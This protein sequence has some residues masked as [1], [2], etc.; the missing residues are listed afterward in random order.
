MAL[1]NG[2]K[3]GHYEILAL[4]GKGGMGEV[5]RAH[6]AVLGREVA[7]KILPEAFAR[8]PER[9]AR[10]FD[11]LMRAGKSVQMFVLTCRKRLFAR[12]ARRS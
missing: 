1:A 4:I 5:Y 2:S 10:M 8:D 11:I 7:L 12:G 3:L 9:I 6:D